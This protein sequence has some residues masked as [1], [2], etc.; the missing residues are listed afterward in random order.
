[1]AYA[2]AGRRSGATRWSPRRSRSSRP[3]RCAVAA[4]RHASSSPTS[5][6]D[7]GNLDP[8]GRGGGRPTATRV[9]AAVDYAGHPAE[10]DALR[11]VADRARRRADGGRR[12][13]DRRRATADRPVGALADLTT[14]SFFPTKNITTAEGGAVAAADPDARSRRA[15]RSATTGWSATRASCASRDEGGWH[16]EVHEFGL[17]YRLPDVLCALG[18][19]QL[20]R[21]AA[22]KARRAELVARYDAALAGLA[23][24][25]LPARRPYVGPRLA[26]LRRCGSS[27][28]GGG[29]STTGCGRAGIGVQVNY[30]PGLLAPGLRGPR[31]PA[32]HV[33]GRRGASTPSSCRCRCSPTSPIRTRTGSSKPST[34]SSAERRRDAPHQP[35]LRA[36]PCLG[37]LLRAGRRRPAAHPRLPPARLEHRRRAR[38]RARSTSPATPKFVWS[39]RIRRRALVAG[40]PRLRTSSARPGAT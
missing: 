10:Y 18:L 22:F 25:R 12:P 37:P 1:M 17:N 32:R 7:T 23:G 28:G 9:V 5:S 8:R 26:P 15:R 30:M 14:F 4:R 13:L 2:A 6:D 16:Q 40:A 35:F 39:E 21:L 31:L 24:L 27:T 29:R 3:P 34:R 19:S 38:P 20:R 36:R 11:K 33:P